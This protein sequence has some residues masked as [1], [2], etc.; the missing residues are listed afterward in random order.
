MVGKAAVAARLGSGWLPLAGTRREGVRPWCWCLL[1]VHVSTAET[2]G[3]GKRTAESENL[4][5]RRGGWSAGGAGE[6]AGDGDGEGELANQTAKS[7]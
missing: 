4:D 7:R 2:M 3:S 5:Q 6:E 1:F